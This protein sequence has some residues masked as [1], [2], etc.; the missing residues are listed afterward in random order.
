MLTQ[1]NPVLSQAVQMRL[2]RAAGSGA[3]VAAM[4]TAS[5]FVPDQSAG[6]TGLMITMRARSMDDLTA[7]A[8]GQVYFCPGALQ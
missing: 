2:A 6:P 4:E 3:L 8:L 7:F 5:A 1:V